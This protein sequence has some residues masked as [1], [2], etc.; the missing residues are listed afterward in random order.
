MGP[1][2]CASVGRIHAFHRRAPHRNNYLLL[3]LVPRAFPLRKK[4]WERGCLLLSSPNFCFF[5]RFPFSL[6][7]FSLNKSPSTCLGHYR[8]R[9]LQLVPVQ[10]N[11]RSALCYT[12]SLSFLPF[13]VVYYKIRCCFMT[14]H[15][16]SVLNLQ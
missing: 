4:P 8:G 7:S 10:L 13:S 1:G 16:Y 12:Q 2:T 9:Q 11:S 6:L 5:R 14:N 3:N 15:L